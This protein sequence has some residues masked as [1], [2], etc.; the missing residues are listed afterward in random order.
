MEY[1]VCKIECSEKGQIAKGRRNGAAQTLA[2]EV[3]GDHSLW[4]T[5]GASNSSPVAEGDCGTPI[6][7]AVIR[8]TGDEFLEG[9][10]GFL[11][12]VK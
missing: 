4:M 3:D 2:S 8:I 1:I 11:V 12:I 9:Q 7:R 10:Q 5:M 6:G